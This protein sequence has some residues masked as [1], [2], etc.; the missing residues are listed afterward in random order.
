M[1]LNGTQETKEIKTK[2]KPKKLQAIKTLSQIFIE[3]KHKIQ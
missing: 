1:Y 3:Y 2:K